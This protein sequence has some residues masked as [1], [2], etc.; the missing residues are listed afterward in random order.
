MFKG[1]SSRGQ[2]ATME[3]SDLAIESADRGHRIGWMTG[4]VSIL[5]LLFSGVSLYETVLKQAAL[6]TFV[7]ETIAYTRDPNGGYEVFVVPLAIANTGARDGL[8]S[9]MSLTVKNQETGRERVF[10]A[11]FLAGDG[12]L[13]TKEDFT[14]GLTRPKTPFVPL[15][16]AGRASRTASVLF[17]P[18][19][20]SRDRVLT[21]EGTFSFTLT[22]KSEGIEKLGYFDKL[23]VNDLKP[24]RF[25]ANLPQVSSYFEGQINSGFSARMFVNSM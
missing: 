18:R 3:A 7:P 23:W 6:H 21:K 8:I 16:V 15:A 5:A 2:S 1:R 4:L 17:Y 12:Y 9:A 19:E 13:S 20:A 10:H 25:S 22:S 24:V 14:K 11:S